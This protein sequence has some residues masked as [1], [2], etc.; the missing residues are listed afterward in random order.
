MLFGLAEREKTYFNKHLERFIAL[1][2]C[3]YNSN[4]PDAARDSAKVF[5]RFSDADV[6]Y[7]NRGSFDMNTMRVCKEFGMLSDRCILWRNYSG[8]RHSMLNELYYDQIWTMKR[9]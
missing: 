8:A 9:F 5:E 1:A 4:R 2:P 6:W 7:E 3:V